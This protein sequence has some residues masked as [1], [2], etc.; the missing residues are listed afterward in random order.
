MAKITIVGGGFG[1]IKAA[2]ELSIDSKNQITLISDQPNFIYYPSLYSTATGYSYRESWAPLEKIFA[3]TKNVKVVIDK[4]TKVDPTKRQLVGKSKSVYRYYT[5]VLALGNTTTYF[6]IDGMA[7]YSFGIKSQQEIR[8]LQAHLFEDMSDGSD[9]E[10]NYIVVGGGPTGVELAGALGEYILKLREYFGIRKKSL[11]IGIIESSDR[12]LP[13]LHKSSSKAATKRLKKLGVR[14]TTGKAV[15]RLTENTIMVAGKELATET[16]I[17]TSGVAPVEFYQKNQKWFEFDKRGR[18]VVDDYM[19]ARKDIYVIGDN[20]STPYSG[21]AQT[22]LHDGY[23]VARRIMGSK[24]KYRPKLP[25]CVIP[26]GRKWA[27]FEW[28][29]LRFSGR[30]AA[31]LHTA[32]GFIG[33]RDVLPLSWAIGSWHARTKPELRLPDDLKF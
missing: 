7:D 32:A 4:I 22:A 14:V 24:A 29:L 15:E 18:V 3:D 16:V 20:A 8:R 13:R 5:L 11:R 12:L 9:D 30:S 6:N 25:P 1:G 21:L 2:Q 26:I 23:F 27:L 28:G 17:W 19:Q 31:W 33:H 10:K